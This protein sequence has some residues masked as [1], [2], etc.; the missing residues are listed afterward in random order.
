MLL[1][2]Q[3]APRCQAKSKRS[4][5]QCGSP[6][7]KGKRVCRMHG[8]TGG[9]PTGNCNARKHGYYSEE[10]ISERRVLR[11]LLKVSRYT[12]EQVDQSPASKVLP[13]LPLRSD[14]SLDEAQ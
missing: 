4:G 7:V 11:A 3:Q 8:A 10:A 9:A 12:V 6:A 14:T 13:E 2:M 1:D 5:K